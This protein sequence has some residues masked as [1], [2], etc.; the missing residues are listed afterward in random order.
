MCKGAGGVRIARRAVVAGPLDI[1]RVGDGL[2]KVKVTWEISVGA[3]V[4]TRSALFSRPVRFDKRG[5]GLSDPVPLHEIP[6]LE[7]GVGPVAELYPPDGWAKPDLDAAADAMRH[8][9]SHPDVGVGRE[10]A[11]PHDAAAGAASLPRTVAAST[12]GEPTDER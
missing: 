2:A 7:L 8:L 10:R 12:G 9:Y 11:L 4:N 1:R 5:V 6:D 3:Q